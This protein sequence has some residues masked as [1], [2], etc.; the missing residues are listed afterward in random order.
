[1]ATEK[2]VIRK[3]MPLP[4]AKTK[5]WRAKAAYFEKYSTDELEAAGYLKPLSAKEE[6]VLDKL[7]QRAQQSV[8]AR[9]N[10]RQLNLTVPEEALNRLEQIALSQY[11]PAT[12]L[13][14]AWLLQRLEKESGSG[15]F[16]E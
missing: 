12:T 2:Q 1:M 8:K 9:K 11:I 16:Q 14:R 6:L 3:K 7:T 13:A 15:K 4:P 10:R 5:S